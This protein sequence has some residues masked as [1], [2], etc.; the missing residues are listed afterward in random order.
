MVFLITLICAIGACFLL[1]GA[2]RKAPVAFYIAAICLDALY[3]ASS[4]I[5]MPRAIWLALF[6][7]IQKCILPLALFTIVMYIG[8]FAKESFI[9]KRLRPI[10]SELS[11][12]AW[13]LS[14]GHVTVYLY[15]YLPQFINSGVV[16]ENV[17]IAFSI[18]IALLILL[19]VLGITSFNFVKKCMRTATWTIVQKAAYV[20][21]ALTFAHLAFMLL[22]SALSGGTAA[23]AS[24]AVYFAVFGLYAVMRVC[25]AIVD[26]NALQHDGS[27]G[28]SHG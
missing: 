9:S 24:I 10:R 8:C 1:H 4:F 22:P 5:E 25:R 20:F 12:I 2:I 26:R 23:Q 19:M 7:M 16:S 13:L 11:I 3:V 28:K 27:L 14:L 6:L 15:A 17:S 18:A 21:F